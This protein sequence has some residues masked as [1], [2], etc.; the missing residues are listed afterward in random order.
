[1]RCS[2]GHLFEAELPSCHAPA[3]SCPVCGAEAARHWSAS[4]SIGR[5]A[6]PGPSRDQMP[7]SWAAVHR[8]DR[9]A[10]EWWHRQAKVRERNEEKHPELAGDRRPF[11]AHEGVFETKPLRMGDPLPTTVSRFLDDF[12]SGRGKPAEGGRDEHT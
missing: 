8:G 5:R 3:P 11:L 12:R 7:K 10:V 9:S 4:F 1:M 2:R 6:K